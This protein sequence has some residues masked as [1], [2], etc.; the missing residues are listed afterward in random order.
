[1]LYICFLKICNKCSTNI[2]YVG[3]SLTNG[4]ARALFT[5]NQE[6]ILR[7]IHMYNIRHLEL[8]SSRTKNRKIKRVKNCFP[9]GMSWGT[10]DMIGDCFL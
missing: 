10:K 6:K 2:Q 1:M 3:I 4:Y 5:E 9:G 8:I 7:K